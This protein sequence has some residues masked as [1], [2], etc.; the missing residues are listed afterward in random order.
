MLK[1]HSLYIELYI[2]HF[3]LTQHNKRRKSHLSL[4]YIKVF[5]LQV[6]HVVIGWKVEVLKL[7]ETQILVPFCTRNAEFATTNYDPENKGEGE[8]SKSFSSDE[9]YLCKSLKLSMFQ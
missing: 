3:A 2:E 9:L 8:A 4:T 6:V 7:E 5:L 1:E